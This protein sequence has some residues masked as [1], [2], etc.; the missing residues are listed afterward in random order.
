MTSSTSELAAT[1]SI[2]VNRRD[3]QHS[4]DEIQRS[5]DALRA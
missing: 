1:R 2:D 5:L 4:K 3:L